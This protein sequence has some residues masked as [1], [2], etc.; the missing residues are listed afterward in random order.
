[1]PGSLDEAGFC[2]NGG[3]RLTRLTFKKV[4]E[5]TFSMKLSDAK[6]FFFL[7]K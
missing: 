3:K 6:V 5:W 7:P 4:C 2:F 1:M